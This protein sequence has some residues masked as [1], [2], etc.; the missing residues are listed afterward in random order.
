[1]KKT[2]QKTIGV[3]LS[4]LIAL[5]GFGAAAFAEG[6][7][8]KEVSYVD[9]DGAPQTAEAIVAAPGSHYGASDGTGWYVIEGTYSGDGQLFFED[10]VTNLILADDADWTITN[11]EFISIGNVKSG[12]G[13]LNVFAQA[14][15]SA[16]LHLSG[17]MLSYYGAMNVYGGTVISSQRIGGSPS[18]GDFTAGNCTLTGSL[19]GKNITLYN[20]TVTGNTGNCTGDFTID[21]GTYTSVCGSTETPVRANSIVIAN[22]AVEGSGGQ[23]GLQATGGSVTISNSSVNITASNMAISG[24]GVSISGGSVTATGTGN[25]GVYSSGPIEITG[26][27]VTAEGGAF[28]LYGQGVSITGGNVTASGSVAGVNAGSLLTLGADAPD[29]SYTL[30]SVFS[31]ATVTVKEGQTL[32]DGENDYTETLTAEQVAALAGKTLTCKHVMADDWT[33]YD[34]TRH[35]K[36]CTVCGGAPEYEDHDVIVRGAGDATCGAEG[37]TGDEYCSVCGQRLSEGEVTPPTGDHVTE[38][39]NVKEATATEDGY[40]GDEVCTVCGQTVRR[41]ETI[42]ATGET[43]D[44]EVCP[45]CGKVHTGSFARWVSIL[46]FIYTFLL[47]ILRVIR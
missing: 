22:A 41:G 32:T 15:N 45:I 14:D 4:L 36:V 9:A 1:M 8:T 42:P 16:T 40:T 31:G 35:V 29:S 12:G 38:L 17:G 33:Y 21:G 20:C 43:D 19:Y 46:Y 44:G 26:G 2:T 34:G 11:P 24:R 47:R 13:T 30:G 23:N 5:S 10:A 39:V 37:Y 27:A 7:T 3:L 6:E 28:G 18:S 25:F